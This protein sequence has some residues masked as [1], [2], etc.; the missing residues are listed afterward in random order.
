MVSGAR[1]LGIKYQLAV[2]VSIF[3]GLFFVEYPPIFVFLG[4]WSW[5]AA[6]HKSLTG[7]LLILN[8]VVAQ[9]ASRRLSFFRDAPKTGRRDVGQDML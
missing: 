8:L 9:Y 6:A 3:V 1:K 2:A 7:I 4:Y 5:G